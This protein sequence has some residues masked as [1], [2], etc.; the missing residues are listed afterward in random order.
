[1][2]PYSDIDLIFLLPDD[3]RDGI[4][5][6]ITTMLH[7]VWDSKVETG[8]SVRTVKECREEAEKDLAVLTSLL[9]IRLI[10]GSQ[11][12]FQRLVEERE[13]LVDEKDPLDLYLLV[14]DGI[15]LSCEQNRTIYLLEP[16]LK[17]GPGSLRYVQLIA[18]LSQMLFG[19][20]GLA[21]LVLIG[22]C[23]EKSVTEARQAVAFVAELRTRLHYMT[24][25]GEDRLSFD[26]QARMAA[27]LG[28][29]DTPRQPGVVR[30]M[31]DYYR[32]AATLDF[33]GRRVLAWARLY[34][35]PGVVPDVKRLKINDSFYIGAGG[36][37]RFDTDHFCDTPLELLEA[38]RMIAKT[39]CELD[40]RLVD[41][42]GSRLDLVDDAFINDP[43]ANS[44]FVEIFGLKGTV[45]KAVRA[46]MKTGFLERFIR[47]F[48]RIRCLPTYDAYHHYTVDQHTILVL[49]GLDYFSR[50]DVD[51]KDGLLKTIL[52]RLE[53]PAVLYL[54]A[55]FHDMG[56]GS[57]AGHE[58]RGEV[59]ARPVLERLGL[60]S[61]D[62]EDVCFLIRNHLA[63]PHLAFRKDIHDHGLIGR[64][65]ETMATKRRLDLLYL[66]THAD[67]GAV[68]PVDMGPWRRLLLEEVYY[69]TIDALR[70]ESAGGE[71]LEEWLQEL[72]WLIPRLVLEQYRDVHLD[73]FIKGTT[74]RY[75]LD[76]YPGVIAEHYV[77]I[78]EHLDKTGLDSLQPTEVVVRRT[79][80]AEP[81][82]T[83]VTLIASDRPGLFFRFAGALSANG[84]N[85]LSAWTH[86]IGDNVVV[87][88]FHCN[89]VLGGAL[90]DGERWE[91]F[92]VT[93]TKVISGE[94]DIGEVMEKRRQAN[95]WSPRK[96]VRTYPLRVEIDNAASDRATI[97]EVY[98]QD[99]PGLL[100]DIG[101]WISTLKLNI[102]LTKITTERDQ[103]ADIF[104]VMD[105][106]GNKIVDFNR[107]DEI[108]DVLTDQLAKIEDE[109]LRREAEAGFPTSFTICG[110]QEMR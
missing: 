42:I 95:E 62:V 31:R 68:G 75:L 93:V 97:V 80:H 110:V 85:I 2:S 50:P 25:R 73:R 39:D 57:G 109:I 104:Y 63:I 44:I 65:A 106:E 66:L 15:R 3:P 108:K 19:T 98:A 40:I 101:R 29:T 13:T 20:A 76:F 51:E 11:E 55:L 58:V 26:I 69:R 77:V 34:L 28:Y 47:E 37:N 41:L 17:E 105:Q 60:P 43:R 96:F 23:D 64:F 1:M 12:T 18:W 83:A 22:V 48:G 27:H 35:R 59:I 21:D 8:Y 24:A 7:M 100:Y 90:A 54:A 91:R 33:F 52:S 74:P 87:A 81:G 10:W 107:L 6:A 5:E 84:I 94:L 36:I 4:F 72:R 82:Y 9:D 86:S 16:H 56:K 32:H 45:G 71:D 30:F 102:L 78:R 89:D 79:D 92:N 49:E 46:M 53:N 14:E 103:A 38:F 70:S 67:L 88:T 61:R 99:R